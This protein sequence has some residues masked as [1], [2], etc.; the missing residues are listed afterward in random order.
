MAMTSETWGSRLDL[1]Q[2]VNV[3][4]SDRSMSQIDRDVMVANLNRQ[5][6]HVKVF[7]GRP[8][9]PQ[10]FDA[11]LRKLL[12]RDEDFDKN[13]GT[14]TLV[15]FCGSP[16]LGNVCSRVKD[17][18]SLMAALTGNTNHSFT[19]I[20]E[21]YGQ[22][23]SAVKLQAFNESD[24]GSG[25]KSAFLSAEELTNKDD[26]GRDDNVLESV[27]KADKP[28]SLAVS[29]LIEDNAEP[30]SYLRRLSNRFSTRLKKLSTR[31]TDDP[32]M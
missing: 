27:R 32:L 1:V 3:Y 9:L 29:S 6:K 4:V 10:L 8:S 12:A 20:Q 11:H 25:K 2:R 14:S 30:I 19:F 26:G 31:V 23:T 13:L 7:P 18:T 24:S 5:L 17:E 21:N 22:G 15:T 16:T 28:S